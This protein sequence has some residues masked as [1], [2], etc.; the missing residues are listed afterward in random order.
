MNNEKIDQKWP[1]LN[2]IIWKQK[3]ANL[4]Y[5]AGACLVLFLGWE[6]NRG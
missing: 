6:Y 4:F 1:P 2:S 5:L 3:F